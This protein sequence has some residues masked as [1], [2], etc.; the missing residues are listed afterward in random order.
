M[1]EPGL[2]LEDLAITLDGHAMLRLSAHV[3][4]GQ[5]VSV[6]GP[7]GSYHSPLPGHAPGDSRWHAT[8]ACEYRTAR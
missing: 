4:P 3:R 1:A 8:L 6:M 7:S 2:M 5:V